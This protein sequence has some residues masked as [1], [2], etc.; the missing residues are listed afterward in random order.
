MPFK[1]SGRNTFPD[2]CL[3]D[4]PE[5]YEIKGPAW[6]GREREYDSNSQAPTGCHDGRRIFYVFG[7]Y[8]ADLSNYAD[9]GN[10]HKRYPVVDLVICH[11][12]FLNADR[13]YIHKNKSARGFGSYGD[14]MIRDRKMRVAPTPFALTKRCGPDDPGPAGRLRRR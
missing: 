12:D 3:V 7:R 6:P 2:F 14:V 13:N 8:P 1:S 11:G 5:G 9:Q 4:R 10:G